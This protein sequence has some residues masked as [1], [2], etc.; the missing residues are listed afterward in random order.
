MAQRSV[1]ELLLY[2]AYREREYRT[3]PTS[4][5]QYQDWLDRVI[6]MIEE[7]LGQPNLRPE[8]ANL[9][10][11]VLECKAMRDLTHSTPSPYQPPDELKD[12]DSRGI[13]YHL[14]RVV[15]SWRNEADSEQDHPISIAA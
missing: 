10:Q 4:V 1:S 12:Q 2:A 8:I 7:L 15:G 3:S 5:A 13:L 11:I 9:G 14:E 6:K